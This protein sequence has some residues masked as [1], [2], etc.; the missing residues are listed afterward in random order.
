[1]KFILAAL[2]ALLALARMNSIAAQPN[3]LLILTDDLGYGSLG[4][5]GNKEIR[6]PNIDRLAASGMRFTDF[7]SNGAVCSPTRAALMTGR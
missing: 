5:Y 3:F 6:T 4:C 7:H 1:M 2:L